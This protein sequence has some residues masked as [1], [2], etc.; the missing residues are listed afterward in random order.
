[1]IF[2]L[3]TYL[4]AEFRCDIRRSNTSVLSVLGFL[5]SAEL[6]QLIA[7]KESWIKLNGPKQ[8]RTVINTGTI[9]NKIGGLFS[10]MERP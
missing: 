1:M 6:N 8:N 2:S 3:S 5:I 4:V 10:Q 7:G 9:R